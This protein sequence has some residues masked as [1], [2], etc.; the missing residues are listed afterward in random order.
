VVPV[1]RIAGNLN[2]GETLKWGSS[3]LKLEVWGHIERIS[4]H[5]QGIGP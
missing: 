4:G 2:V 5:S 3:I 1:L